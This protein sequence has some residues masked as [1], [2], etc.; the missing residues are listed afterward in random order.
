MCFSISYQSHNCI[1][2]SMHELF[3]WWQ[4]QWWQWTNPNNWFWHWKTPYPMRCF[5]YSS[6][7]FAIFFQD[8]YY[9]NYIF[10]N[11]L[12]TQTTFRFVNPFVNIGYR[13]SST[14]ANCLLKIKEKLSVCVFLRSVKIY[15]CNCCGHLY[16]HSLHY[17]IQKAICV[18]NA[19]AT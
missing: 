2:F 8:S 14:Q 6:A 18:P 12:V 7:I 10:S 5:A 11:A 1:H 13:F 16:I 3:L 19:V 15:Q 4:S 17:H 9:L